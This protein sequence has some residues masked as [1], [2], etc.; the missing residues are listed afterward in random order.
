MVIPAA[1][2]AASLP[3]EA[4][5]EAPDLD[6]EAEAEAEDAWDVV[7]ALA[8]VVDAEAAAAVLELPLM[9]A[10]DCPSISDCTVVLNV[11]DMPLRLRSNAALG[12]MEKEENEGL[13]T[14]TW[15][16]KREQ[17]IEGM[18]YPSEPATRTE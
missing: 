4:D 1:P 8:A 13:L 11:P 3:A 18:Q 7:D 10:V 5:A 9:G 12:G 16:R 17:G 15:R 6:A 14:Q 2:L